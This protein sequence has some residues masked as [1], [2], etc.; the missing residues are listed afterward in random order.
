M[1]KIQVVLL[2]SVGNIKFGMTKQEVREKY[3]VKGEFIKNDCSNNLTDDLGFCHVYYNDE[4]NVTETKEALVTNLIYNRGSGKTARVYFNPEDEKY[5]PMQRAILRGTDDE[6]REE[7][8][9]IYRE[10]GLANRDSLVNDF[11][12]RRNKNQSKEGQSQKKSRPNANSRRSTANRDKK[13]KQPQEKKA[14]D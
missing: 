3:A 4:G 10:A 14:S 11:Y 1:K 2:E 5:V 6:V 7:I 8:N 12:K 13:A 9:K